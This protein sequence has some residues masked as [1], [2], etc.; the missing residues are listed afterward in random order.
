MSDWE[1][2]PNPEW[3]NRVPQHFTES[4][5]HDH[6][7]FVTIECSCGEQMHMHQTQ[8]ERAPAWQGI[9]SRCHACGKVLTFEPGYFQGVLAA[10]R[11]SGWI[12]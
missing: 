9:A 4:L 6:S 8:W 7:H 10:M 11:E 12:A 5:C 2:V 3:V 1:L